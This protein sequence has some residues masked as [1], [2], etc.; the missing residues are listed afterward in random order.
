[1]RNVEGN[2]GGEL[3]IILCVEFDRRARPAEVSLLKCALVESPNCIHS[4]DVTGGF[5]LIA[6]FAAPGI[7]WYKSWL[8]GLADPFARAVNRYEANFV[9][10]RSFRRAIDEDAVWVPENGGFKRIDSAVIDKVTAEGDYVRIH[11]QGDSWMLH[12]TMKSVSGRLRSAHFIRIHR[13]T[14]V[15][16]QFIDR[17]ARECRHWVAHLA[18][19]TVE[20]VA[21]SHVNETLEIVR[22]RPPQ[23]RQLAV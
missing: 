4:V 1:V 23:A 2:N 19:G 17:V 10:E 9:F 22:S 11:S 18:D 14:I 13:S 7:S 20:P 8:A 3:R 12:E 21:R 16:F 5:D 15:R 6:E